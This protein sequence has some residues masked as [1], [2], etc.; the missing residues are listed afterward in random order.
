MTGETRILI[1]PDPTTIVYTGT[2]IWGSIT[3]TLSNQVDLQNAFDLKLT[4]TDFN[5]YSGATKI[6]LDDKEEILTFV[7]SGGTSIA[8]VGDTISVSSAVPTGTTISW[9]DI[10]GTVS[11]QIDLQA[12]L[13]LKLA[14]NDFNIYTGDTATEIGLKASQTDFVTH[15][16]DSTI[17][18]EQSGITIYENQVTY[19]ETDLTYLSGLT[20]I[21][22]TGITANAAAITG[23]TNQT[24]FNTHTGN[25]TI[26][27]SGHTFTQSGITEISQ[28][29]ND[30]TIYVPA[31]SITGVTWGDVTSKPQWLSGT[32]L[33]AFET[34]HTH[35]Q[36]L[37][38]VT[39]SEVSSKPDL[40]LTSTFS[41]YTGATATAIGLK[42][43]TTDFNT[44]TG[45][46]DTR[47]EGIE[48]DITGNTAGIATNA[49]DIV[50]LSGQTDLKLTTTDFNTYSGLTAT[51]IGL[52]ADLTGAT[53]TGEI[54]GTSM[55]LSGDLTVDGTMH[56]I[57]T[58]Q[59]WTENDFIYMRSGAT[60]GL[61]IGQVSGIAAINVDGSGTTA[62]MGVT[63]DGIIRVGWTGDTL[64]AIAG[65]EDSPIDG[66]YAY[67]DNTTNIFKTYDLRSD[68]TGNTANIVTVSGLTETN[69]SDIIYLSGQTDLKLTT[70]DFNT[71]SG[72][73]ATAI[74]LKASQADFTGHTNDTTIH[75]T[76]AEITGKTLQTDF[77]THTGDTGIHFEMNDITGFTSSDSFN[78]YTGTTAPAQFL[79]ITGL[80][81]YWTSAQTQTELDLKTDVTLFNTFTGNTYTKTETDNLI[82]ITGATASGETVLDLTDKILTIYSPT[83]TTANTANIVLKSDKLVTINDKTGTT[84]TVVVGDSD[85]ILEASNTGATTITL[86]SGLTTGFQVTI[87]NIGAQTITF[88][89]QSGS[90]LRSKDSA[91]TCPNEF[92]AVSAYKNG[93]YWTLIGDIE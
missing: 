60:S 39:W 20:A 5:T 64:V 55:Q 3:G 32:T 7:A 18:F 81:G 14:I 38:G 21:N 53:F 26:H 22:A 59:V 72:A 56:V 8:R 13:N 82:T 24:D 49:S 25:T 85:E 83:G 89:A 16:G 71:Y 76:Q 67:W 47:L 35:S 69:S 73:T 91:V 86:A 77:V 28:I 19:L 31:D 1:N 42:L 43:D 44:Y 46:T 93:T 54:Q 90:T 92:G 17:H 34:G 11:N 40:V 62:V 70:T 4:T 51:A 75:F 88:A 87:V 68:V 41:G 80:T 52:K 63:Q 58:E 37:T 33:G 50:Y 23:K 2:T 9:G 36:Y 84:Y 48:D 45:N 27:F 30:I 78:T 10:G 65:R 57:H 66:G 15:T 74:G 6:I 29:G 79:S 61:G 12:A